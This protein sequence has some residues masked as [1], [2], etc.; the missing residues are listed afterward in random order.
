MGLWG[1]IGVWEGVR[2]FPR[3][4]PLIDGRVNRGFRGVVYGDLWG[5]LGVFEG[6]KAA[7]VK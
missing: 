1:F 2:G 5:F 7:G 6:I 3:G 4:V